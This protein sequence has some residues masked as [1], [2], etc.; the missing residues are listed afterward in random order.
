M[1]HG[2]GSMTAGLL[3][4]S[5]RLDPLPDRLTSIGTRTLLVISTL[6]FSKAVDWRI[7][8]LG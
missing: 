4:L 5:S 3:S 2:S 1:T 6:V 8:A 7:G